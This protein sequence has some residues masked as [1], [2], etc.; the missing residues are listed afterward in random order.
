MIRKIKSWNVRGL[1]DPK[2]KKKKYHQRMHESVETRLNLHSRN[3]TGLCRRQN[4]QERV[5]SS[6]C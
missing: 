4:R 5:E 6:G 2:K 1:I 3:Q